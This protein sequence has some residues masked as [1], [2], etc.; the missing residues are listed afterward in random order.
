VFLQKQKLKKDNEGRIAKD[1]EEIVEENM[2]LKSESHRLRKE[3]AIIKGKVEV[4]RKRNERR[5]NVL[6]L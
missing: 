6:E 4:S 2:K 1:Y 3:L 5:S